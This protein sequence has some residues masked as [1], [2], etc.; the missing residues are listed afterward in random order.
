VEFVRELVI[1]IVNVDGRPFNS[2]KALLTKPG[3]LTAEFMR[4]SRMPYLAPVQFFLIMNLAFFVWS[5][6]AG[7]RFFDTP[8]KVQLNSEGYS[9]IARRMVRERL[10]RNPEDENAYARRFDTMGTAQARSLVG[11]MIPAF[12]LVVGIVTFSLKKR[13]PVVKHL[14]FALHSYCF[15]FVLLCVS[16]Y[17]IDLPVTFLLKQAGVPPGPLEYDMQRSLVSMSVF[18]IYLILSLRRAYDLTRLRSIAGAV[19]LGAGFFTILT[20]YRG[21]LFWVTFH[22]V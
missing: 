21:L 2:L 4:G 9:D 20:A 16:R 13:T 1:E 22:S 3:K 8:L 5:A 15:L 14:V 18:V 10:T 19:I 12:A 11:V 6:A 7:S 17:L